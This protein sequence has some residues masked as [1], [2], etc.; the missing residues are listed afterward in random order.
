M[1]VTYEFGVIHDCADLTDPDVGWVP[2][3]LVAAGEGWVFL[4]IGDNPSAARTGEVLRNLIEAGRREAPRGE[5]LAWLHERLGGTISMAPPEK[6][7][8]ELGSEDVLHELL[9]RLGALS[10][11]TETPAPVPPPRFVLFEPLAGAA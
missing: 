8:V 10:A 4:G 6:R 7:E 9:V 2:V 1:K 5:L 3:G 11:R